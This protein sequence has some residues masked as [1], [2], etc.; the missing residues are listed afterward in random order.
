MSVATETNLTNLT[1]LV[2][3]FFAPS[4]DQM[5]EF[6]ERLNANGALMK[7]LAAKPKVV[8]NRRRG[9]NPF[10][11]Y[12]GEMAAEIKEQLLQDN[13]ELKGRE[14]QNEITKLAG[15]MWR[16][17]SDEEKAPF[18]AKFQAKQLEPV[19]EKP[20]KTK[21]VKKTAAASDP[22]KPKRAPNAYIIYKGEKAA[23]IKE[24]LLQDNPELKGRELQTEITKVAGAM[25]KEMTDDEKEV[26]NQMRVER[27]KEIDEA[28]GVVAPAAPTKKAAKAPEKAPKAPKAPKEKTG[29]AL[30]KEQFAA[31]FKEEIANDNPELKGRA[32]NSEIAAYAKAKWK[33]MTKEE[34]KEFDAPKPD[35]EEEVEQT[36]PEETQT[37][38]EEADEDVPPP[39][40][41][42]EDEQ[43][44]EEEDDDTRQFDDKLNVWVETQTGL[45]YSDKSGGQPVG[46]KV[47]GQMKKLGKQRK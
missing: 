7:L 19:V 23:E 14:L 10:I 8:A 27:Q 5:K 36:Q 35:E 39:P 46:Q 26:Y 41:D 24:Q 43:D 9:G 20:A 22:A 47:R 13:S 33:E 40:S 44:D 6:I 38:E 34:K 25:W 28:A 29:Y 37:E 45:C 12:K 11:I 18:Q 2:E 17:L 30:F 3:E 4:Q 31:Q 15:K 21:R 16:A 32:L 42:S 1:S